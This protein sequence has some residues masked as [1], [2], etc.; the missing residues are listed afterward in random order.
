MKL[1]KLIAALFVAGECALSSPATW[2]FEINPCLRVLVYNTYYL[3]QAPTRDWNLCKKTDLIEGYAN[4]KYSKG[5]VHEHM[6]NFAIDE[7]RGADFEGFLVR[8]RQTDSSKP[9]RLIFEYMNDPAWA[10]S[11]SRTPHNTFAIIYGSWWNDDPL[12]Y[13]W[14]ESKDFRNGLWNLNGQFKPESK[15]YA[16]GREDCEVEGKNHLGW[17]SHYG[18]LQY[19]HF[20][21]SQM[22][23]DASEEA[24]LEETTRL[25]LVWI[26]FAYDVATGDTPF[27]APLTPQI[28]ASLGLPSIALNQCVKQ[29]NVKIRTLFARSGVP[30]DDRNK[31]T[32]DVALGSILHIFQ[33]SFSPAHTCRKEEVVDGSH[34]AVLTQAYNYR[35]QAKDKHGGDEHSFNDKYPGWLLTYARDGNH[36][37]ANDPVAV[38]AWMLSAVDTKTPW[39][40]VEKHLRETIFRKHSAGVVDQSPCIG[41]R[42]L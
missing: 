20:M 3:D 18:N 31:R 10:K 4:G 13:T 32:P 29:K 16:G 1:A 37:Y 19:L 9:K 22:P 26:K 27:D 28:E 35:V 8:K 11:P 25:A 14:G 40:S 2:G 34:Y 12:M 38:G 30:I 23:K 21:S 17:N 5:T 24:R 33:D 6:T 36:V 7:Y 42:S 15:K 41:K 39:E